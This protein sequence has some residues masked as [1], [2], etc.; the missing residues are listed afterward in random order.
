MLLHPLA[1]L[2]LREQDV[3]PYPRIVLHKL[4]LIG[5]CAWVLPLYIEKARSS[6]AHKL[7]KDTD[8][9]LPSG[10][11]MHWRSVASHSSSL[12]T[13]WPKYSLSM[14]K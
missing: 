11:L 4:Q 1:H 5:Q 8:T 13:V 6:S 2:L 12:Y 7:D 3:L 14:I 10:H 9:L